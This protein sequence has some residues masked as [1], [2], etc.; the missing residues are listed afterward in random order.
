MS[1]ASFVRQLLV[2]F[3]CGA[4]AGIGPVPTAWATTEMAPPADVYEFSEKAP[5]PQAAAHAGARANAAPAERSAPVSNSGAYLTE[6]PLD[7]PPGRSGMSPKLALS[8]DSGMSRTATVLGAGW[9]LSIPAI[10]R[11]VRNGFPLVVDAGGT[12]RYLSDG[13]AF[14]GPAGELVPAPDGP[15]GA[16]GK[17]YMPER[18]TSPIRYELRSY[19]FQSLN[20]SYW[21]EHLPNG[22][23]RYY[24][25][26]R[27]PA[28]NQTGLIANELGIH[29]WLL[30]KEADPSG[31][32][33]EYDYAYQDEP[34][35]SSGCRPYPVL[36]RV[37]WGG[38]DATGR[39]PPPVERCPR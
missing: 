24:G 20:Q 27:F 38:N 33:I 29:A 17:L 1:S 5:S 30:V 3:L 35:D 2:A 39:P 31:N 25:A 8:Y 37:T 4:M 32:S 12:D 28:S 13:A 34:T 11:S 36:T 9:S 22:V 16:A 15:A 21:I 6:I 19:Q 7:L 23:K 26:S 14:T 18:E 10:S